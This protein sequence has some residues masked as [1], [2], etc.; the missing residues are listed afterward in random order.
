VDVTATG[1]DSAFG[2]S[3]QFS[4]AP[5]LARA[6]V[7]ATGGGNG[8][9]VLTDGGVAATVESSSV[10]GDGFGVANG[11]GSAATVTRV[12]ASRI[13]GGVR[14]GPGTLRCVASYDAGFAPLDSACA[15]VP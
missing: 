2:V 6:T 15:P 13:S 14:A 11:F 10:S 9:G 7:R 1:D 3:N 12:G 5:S 8:I 4:G